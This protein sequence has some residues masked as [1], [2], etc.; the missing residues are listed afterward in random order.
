MRRLFQG[1]ALG[2]LALFAAVWGS[3]IYQLWVFAPSA[4]EPISRINDATQITAGFLA[5]SVG[6]GVAAL[7]GVEVQRARRY[8]PDA[9]LTRAFAMLEGN[10]FL[11]LGI[12]VYTVVGVALLIIWLAR[13]EAA[14]DLVKT[15]ALSLLGWFAGLLAAGFRAG[16]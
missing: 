11:V 8:H 2:Y 1:L 15:F 3:V 16:T 12:L 4:G 6:S 14:P 10:A 9:S 5:V 7:L 13:P